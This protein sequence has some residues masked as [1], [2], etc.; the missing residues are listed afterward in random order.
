ME[1]LGYAPEA[2][3]AYPLHA[4]A[5]LAALPWRL[6][7]AVLANRRRMGRLGQALATRG[8]ALVGGAGLGP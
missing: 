3:R 5:E 7:G 2:R 6:G 1:R 8:R 4:A